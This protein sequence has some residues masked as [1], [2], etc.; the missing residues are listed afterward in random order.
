MKHVLPFPGKQNRTSESAQPESPD[1]L[2]RYP[3][4]DG[5]RIFIGDFDQT[6]GFIRTIT[7]TDR[8]R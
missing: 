5:I 1:P 3:A 8:R 6:V 4:G 2:G 7:E